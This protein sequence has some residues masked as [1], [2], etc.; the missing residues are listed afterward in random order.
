VQALP[1]RAPKPDRRIQMLTVFLIESENGIVVRRR[2][3]EG[4]LAGLWELPN[5]QGLLTS[6]QVIS[7]AQSIGL[8]PSDAVYKRVVKHVFTHV[9]WQMHVWRLPCAAAELNGVWRWASTTE[10]E[11]EITM[12]SA[13]LSVIRKARI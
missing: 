10:L 4:L 8:A 2:A 11:N 13:F 5:L 6:E 1:I 12:P 3:G 7:F 9:E